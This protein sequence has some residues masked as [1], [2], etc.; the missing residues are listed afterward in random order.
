MF[1]F[2]R[3]LT[4]SAGRCQFFPRFQQFVF[5]VPSDCAAAGFGPTLSENRVA[6]S[7]KIEFTPICERQ[8]PLYAL[9][10]LVVRLSCTEQRWQLWAFYRS[11]PL[12]PEGDQPVS[13]P[14]D[15]EANWA[16]TPPPRR[17]S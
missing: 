5:L 8:S 2:V 7:L 11:N 3:G 1:F 9:Y 13:V 14:P 6:A 4:T 12:S 16:I 15:F 10:R 17:S